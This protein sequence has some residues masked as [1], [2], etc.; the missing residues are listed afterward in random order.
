MVRKSI[1]YKNKEVVYFTL[2]E[3]YP[4][5]LI[6]GYLADSKI[7]SEIA[8][9]L[10][11]SFKLYIVDLP[12]HGQS[13]WNPECTSLKSLSEAI[14]RI[15]HFE[16]VQSVFILGH[17][18]GGYV[19][20]EMMRNRFINVTGLI[21]LNSHPFKDDEEKIS[22][23]NKEI[24]LIKTGKKELLI[25]FNMANSLARHN[26]D[27]YPENVRLLE[28]MA[29]KQSKHGMISMLEAMKSRPEYTGFLVKYEI[30]TL[31]ILGSE[32]EKIDYLKVIEQFSGIPHIHIEVL[33][34]CG[35]LSMIEARNLVTDVIINFYKKIS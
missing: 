3:G 29:L 33:K 31:F 20:I 28:E 4:L 1:I 25:R 35:H 21:L 6:H 8:G 17:S 18:M 23:R 5:I 15:M 27:K 13:E 7:W 16:G 11:R 19:A 30:P 12:G 26:R 9:I 14:A 22:N 2:G 32:D 24:E 10:S 34:D